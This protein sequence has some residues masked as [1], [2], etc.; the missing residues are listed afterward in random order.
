MRRSLRI[1]REMFE[2]K[3]TNAFPKPEGEPVKF[4]SW[5][6][7]ANKEDFLQGYFEFPLYHP[8]NDSD[9]KRIRSF[10]LLSLLE[11]QIAAGNIKNIAECGCFKGHSSYAMASLL[12]KNGFK[13]KFYIF[14]SFE[15]LSDPVAQDKTS[16]SI[17]MTD[18]Q[19]DKLYSGNERMFKGNYEE[20]LSIMSVFDFMDVK[21]GWIPDR[22]NEVENEQFSLVHIDVDIYQPTLDSL[23]FFYD[24]LVPGGVIDIDDYGRHFWPG[25]DIAVAEF[26]ASKPKD[27][28]RFIKIP[29]GGAAIIKL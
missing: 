23:H 4:G 20:Y 18:K 22:F 19:L 8:Q 16:T 25:C 9:G 26:L 1:I 17:S 2:K 5:T 12:K 21:K 13:N 24:R 10:F 28:L 6:N 29:L 15:G 27:A 7:F 14:D 3:D 11:G